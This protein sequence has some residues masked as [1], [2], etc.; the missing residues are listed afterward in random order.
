M[1]IEKY[2][3]TYTPPAP[4]ISLQIAAPGEKADSTIHTALI[5]TGADGTF[6]PIAILEELNA[7]IL[8]LTNVRSH[9]GERAYRAAVH[10]ADFVLSDKIRLPNI[11]VVADDWSEQII[12]GRNL[13]NKLHLSLD[14]P[15][16]IVEI[17]E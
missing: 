7:P 8:Y 3:N 12:I 15:Q 6:I 2:S 5:D 17:R 14:G 4:V 16:Q 10:K 9:F 1:K 11:E 13:L